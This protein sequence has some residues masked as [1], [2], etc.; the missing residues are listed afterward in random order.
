MNEIELERIIDNN[1]SNAIKYGFKDKTIDVFLIKNK[2]EA[3]LEFRTFS[4]K[5]KI[6]I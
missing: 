1:L 6:E 3:I 2:N 4:N 5:I